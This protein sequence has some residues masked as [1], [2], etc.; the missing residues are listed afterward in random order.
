MFDSRKFF[1]DKSDNIF[2][3]VPIFFNRNPGDLLS[4]RKGD[5]MQEFHGDCRRRVYCMGLVLEC[6]K[7]TQQ[8]TYCLAHLIM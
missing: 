4:W 5:L 3:M 6:A 8:H 2:T 1:V 7:S